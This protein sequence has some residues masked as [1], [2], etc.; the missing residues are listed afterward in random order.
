M[1]VLQAVGIG[2]IATLLVTVIKQDRPDMAIQVSVVAGIFIFALLI[3]RIYAVVELL[4]TLSDRYNVNIE[5][6]SVLLKVIGISYLTEFGVQVAQDAGERA[7]AGRIELAGKVAIIT[8]SIPILIA[9][10]ELI[11]GIVP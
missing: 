10:L 6:F 5:G 8:V 3:S 4:S 9:I 11:A 2:L 7:I 1:E